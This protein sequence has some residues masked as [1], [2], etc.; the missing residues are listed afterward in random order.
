MD[1][2]N[3]CTNTE[4]E[5]EITR[6]IGGNPYSLLFIPL[7]LHSSFHLSVLCKKKKKKS[8]VILSFS[9][10]TGHCGSHLAKVCAVTAE[11]DQ[12]SWEKESNSTDYRQFG[13]SPSLA[14]S[15]ALLYLHGAHMSTWSKAV[16]WQ[17][18]LETEWM[19]WVDGDAKCVWWRGAGDKGTCC[20]NSKV[21]PGTNWIW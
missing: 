7:S 18:R 1:N 21:G 3:H 19:G 17:G 4:H 6:D 10:Q 8:V 14:P 9:V 13:H 12:K 15:F 2:E 20:D 16:Y 11:G 5:T